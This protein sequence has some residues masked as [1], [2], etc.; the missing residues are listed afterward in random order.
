MFFF[1]KSTKVKVYCKEC[2]YYKFEITNWGGEFRC[3][4][5]LSYI[6]K[7]KK[8]PIHPAYEEERE[9]LFQDAWN[10]NHDNHCEDY[11]SINEIDKN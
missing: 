7:H 6:V 11:E 5:K 4:K 9:Y 3:Y 1:K 8:S 10:K 2:K